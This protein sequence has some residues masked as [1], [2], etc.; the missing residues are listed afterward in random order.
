[1]GRQEFAAFLLPLDTKYSGGR[2]Q[3]KNAEGTLGW[4]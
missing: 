1:M 3:I 4:Y 2:K